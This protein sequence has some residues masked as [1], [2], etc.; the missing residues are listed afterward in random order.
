FARASVLV[1]AE[2]GRRGECTLHRN[3]VSAWH[4][5]GD[6]AREA[7]CRPV[8]STHSARNAEGRFTISDASGAFPPN[9]SPS[10]CYLHTIFLDLDFT[11]Q[12]RRYERAPSITPLRPLSLSFYL[13]EVPSTSTGLRFLSTSDLRGPPSGGQEERT[14]RWNSP[15][16]KEARRERKTSSAPKVAAKGGWT[17]HRE[18]ARKKDGRGGHRDAMNRAVAEATSVSE[19]RRRRRWRWKRERAS[20]HG[21][22]RGAGGDG[23][24]GRSD[25]TRLAGRN[26]L[27]TR[28]LVPS[29]PLAIGACRFLSRARTYVRRPS[30]TSGRRSHPPA[31]SSFPLFPPTFVA[32]RPFRPLP[33]LFHSPA[34]PLAHP[35]RLTYLGSSESPVAEA[36]VAAARSRQR[37]DREERP[38]E[39][40]QRMRKC[41]VMRNG[42]RRIEADRGSFGG[43]DRR[44]SLLM[45]IR[46]SRESE[47]RG[48][49][50]RVNQEPLTRKL[51]ESTADENRCELRYRT[52]HTDARFTMILRP[53]GIRRG[54]TTVGGGD[55]GGGGGPVIYNAITLVFTAVSNQ[56][57]NL[58]TN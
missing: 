44:N 3:T 2:R 40:P 28:A 39:D 35:S 6:P 42:G 31:P 30:P 16:E 25:L 53:C 4:S 20:V 7:S 56:G 41:T 58:V 49:I 27:A 57:D 36:S 23:G 51:R 9:E 32:F 37:E 34:Q 50:V 24:G 52:T 11:H 48:G 26:K 14:E 12:C 5:P 55:G 43:L 33:R 47:K 38:R 29:V 22:A 8:R 19:R 1:R 10:V 17:M 45:Q 21:S 46:D 13:H 15:A 54:V 18:L